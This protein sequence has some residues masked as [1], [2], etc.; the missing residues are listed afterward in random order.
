MPRTMPVTRAAAVLEAPGRAN[1][2]VA[3]AWESFVGGDEGAVRHVRPEIAHGWRRSRELGINPVAQRAPGA[4]E[5]GD[6][7]D[8][9][10]STELGRAGREVLDGFA[11]RVQSSAHVIVLADG[12]GRILYS[13]GHGALQD[14]LERINFMPGGGWA[15]DVVGPNGIGTP[16]ALGRPELVLG[17]EHYCAGWQPW[18]CY[19]APVCDP[20]QGVPVGVVD[21]TGPWSQASH[22]GLVLTGAIAASIEQQLVIGNLRARDAL[23]RRF[24]ELEARWAADALVLLSDRGFVVDANAA[25]LDAGFGSRPVAIDRPLQHTH[26]AL[27]QSVRGAVERGESAE[28][29]LPERWAGPGTRVRIE[30]LREGAR[31]L[32]AVLVVDRARRAARP[33]RR[34][35]AAGS[36]RWYRFADIVGAHPALREALDA[37]RRAAE[38]PGGYPVLIRGETGTGKELVAQAI[39]GASARARGAF[40][41][42]NCAALPAE[43]AESELFGYAPGAFTGAR[44]EGS[45]GRF[46]AAH[47]GTLF[48]DELDSMPSALQAKLLRVLETGEVTRLGSAEVCRVDVRV[49]AASGAAPVDGHAGDLRTDLYHRLA[50][51]EVRL[52]PLRERPA[53][54][55]L[56]AREF[57]ARECARLGRE[58]PRLTPAAL[59]LLAAHAW[60]GNV[61]ELRNCCVRWA[62]MPGTQVIGAE[63]VARELSLPGP[64]SAPGEAVPDALRA[65][66]DDAIRRALA[67]HDGNVTAAARALGVDR[68]TIYRRRRRWSAPGA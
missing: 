59:E 57:L 53:D 50:V 30:A 48:L 26:P 4:L 40:V 44:R 19:G 34:E 12:A 33:A 2:A 13:V 6:I 43:L 63:E 8:L 38:A 24:R 9:L 68:S 23:R 17:A 41:A 62:V 10:A 1:R 18:V 67:A 51:F 3:R 21:I 49:I 52:P 22:D 14:A 11:Q 35:T 55:G 31:R 65:I 20:E 7:A 54:L 15:E 66:G 25:A 36:G 27:W 28:V 47:G 56:L 64:A 37:A 60:P 29:A 16:L 39:H 5:A 45:A 61:R 32:G 42:V 46:E 58:P